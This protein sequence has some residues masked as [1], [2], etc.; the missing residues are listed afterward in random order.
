MIFLDRQDR[1]FNATL[2]VGQIVG[3]SAFKRAG[4]YDLEVV[5]DNLAT[6]KRHF[7]F[8]GIKDA[9]VLEDSTIDYML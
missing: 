3:N 5:K 4:M 9:T 1:G 8:L 6:M 2:S 7:S